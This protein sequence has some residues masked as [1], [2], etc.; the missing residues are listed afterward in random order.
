MHRRLSV[1]SDSFLCQQL[2]CVSPFGISPLSQAGDQSIPDE[3]EWD[4]GYEPAQQDSAEAAGAVNSG[5]GCQQCGKPAKGGQQ[6]GNGG[7]SHGF[8]D[9]DACS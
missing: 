1:H 7:A 2:L 6:H 4:D 8:V 5:G 3:H 9:E